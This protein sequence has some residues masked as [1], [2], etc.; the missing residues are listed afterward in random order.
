MHIDI[1]ETGHKVRQFGGKWHP[2]QRGTDQQRRAMLAA[3]CEALGI[4]PVLE[5]TM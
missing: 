3:K 4:E 5:G 2:R 1:R